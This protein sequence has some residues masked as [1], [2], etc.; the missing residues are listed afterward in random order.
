MVG[1]MVSCLRFRRHFMLCW[2]PE[3]E[4]ISGDVFPSLGCPAHGENNINFV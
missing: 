1:I 3:G 2:D 4:L